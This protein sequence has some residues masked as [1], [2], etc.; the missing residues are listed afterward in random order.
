MGNACVLKP[1]EDAPLTPLRIAALA[2]EAGLP[3]GVAQRRAR[4]G[5]GRRRRAGRAPRPR[6]RLVHRL[7]RGRPLGRPGGRRL[8]RPGHPRA[9][10]QV[11]QHRVRRRRPRRGR[12]R[13]SSTRSCR[14]PGRRA[15]AGSRLLVRAPRARA[16]G[17]A[18]AR[19]LR[20]PCARPRRRRPGPRPADLGRQLDRVARLRRARAGDGAG[21]STGGSSPDDAA[22]R[23]GYFFAPTLF[24]D[25]A[26]DAP[27]AREEVFGPVLAVTA[28]DAED[29]AVAL[30]NGTDYGLIAAVW[31]RDIAR[32]H[33]VARAVRVGQVYVNT[34]RCRRRRRAALRRPTSSPASAGRRAS[35]RCSA[36]PGPR[37]SRS[38]STSNRSRK[39]SDVDAQPPRERA[40]RRRRPAGAR[41]AALAR[42]G[43]HADGQV[44]R[45]RDRPRRGR[46][47]LGRERPPH[48]RHARRA[49]V[50]QRR[51]RTH[52]DRRR[53]RSPDAPAGRLLVVPGV[54]H[55]AGARARGAPG[56]DGADRQPQDLPDQRRR[57][58]GGRHGQADPPLLER[59]RP[60]GEEPAGDAFL[61]LPRAARAR[62]EHRRHRDPQGGAA[63]PRPGHAPHPDQR[64]G[65]ARAADRRARPTRSPPSSASPS[66]AP[67]ASSRRPP[68]TCSACRSCAGPTTSSS[69]PTR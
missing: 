53:R 67:A 29:E 66:S 2:H 40:R 46:L 54:R 56:G 20:A 32:A 39:G 23:G 52:R 7:A 48:A 59:H 55:P 10:R 34:L 68:A 6:P 12:C 22:L 36:T 25:V 28:F 15:R 1:A 9:R 4:P 62:H 35:R 30:A 69:W 50:L 8:D 17:R 61:E 49:L 14:T 41:D 38:A 13:R 31:T 57:R 43:P 37:P 44:A 45:D 65:G 3:D 27:L 16:P 60:A 64:R 47:H 58:R 19:A 26:P 51:A 21:W 5:R 42:P 33:R 24:D 18:G 63:A 11:A